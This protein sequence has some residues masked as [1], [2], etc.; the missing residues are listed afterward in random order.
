[1][2]VRRARIGEKK[3]LSVKAKRDQ[4]LALARLEA[5]VFFINDENAALALDDAASLMAQFQGFQRAGDFH[6]SSLAG[7]PFNRPSLKRA[8]TNA[9]RSALSIR[10]PACLQESRISV[11]AACIDLKDFRHAGYASPHSP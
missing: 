11:Y 7:G 4:D 6:D 10:K 5:G 8:E 2:M 9:Q 3:P 1:M